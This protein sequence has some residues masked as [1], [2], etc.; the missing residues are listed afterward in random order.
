M[1]GTSSKLKMK[2]MERYPGRIT[3]VYLDPGVLQ[4]TDSLRG[5]MSRSKYV[6][7]ALHEYNRRFAILK[8]KI[9]ETEREL[10]ETENEVRALK[11]NAPSPSIETRRQERSA[12]MGF[13]SSSSET[14]VYPSSIRQDKTTIQIPTEGDGEGDPEVE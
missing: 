11:Q 4:E 6:S 2:T 1:S 3:A 5:D 10:D 8:Q 7:K 13:S 12:V 9:A 14:S